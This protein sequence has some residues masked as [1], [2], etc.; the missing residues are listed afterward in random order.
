M[1]NP[2][3]YFMADFSFSSFKTDNL[4][5]IFVCYVIY[6]LIYKTFTVACENS[7]IVF[8]NYF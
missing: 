6:L 1:I 7:K 4:K 5:F 3:T 2:V 8:F